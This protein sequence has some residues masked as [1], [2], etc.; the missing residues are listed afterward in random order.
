[1]DIRISRHAKRRLK[2]RRIVYDEVVEA[3]NN[4]DELLLQSRKG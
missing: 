3:I 1:M 4:P 2:E